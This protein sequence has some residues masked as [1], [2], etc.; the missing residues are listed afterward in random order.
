[1]RSLEV[2]LES[3]S[4]LGPQEAQ[5][6]DSDVEDA[7]SRLRSLLYLATGTIRTLAVSTT[8]VGGRVDAG[9]FGGG[10]V[11]L[12]WEGGKVLAVSR[13]EG[14][15]GTSVGGAVQEKGRGSSEKTYS[16]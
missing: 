12:V 5:Q 2:R 15:V 11:C 8:E 3:R 10:R 1:M 7:T 9:G 13:A 6:L 14:E 4:Q 16:S